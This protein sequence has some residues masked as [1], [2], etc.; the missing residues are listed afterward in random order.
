M[1]THSQSELS[2]QRGNLKSN[3]TDCRC[4]DMGSPDKV[5]GNLESLIDLISWLIVS[6]Y[7]LASA[8]AS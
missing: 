4:S 2:L 7:L 1:E 8:V 5:S 6:K 3:V